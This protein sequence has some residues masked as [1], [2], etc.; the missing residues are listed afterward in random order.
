MNPRHSGTRN[1][2]S[3]ALEL[4]SQ[5][6]NQLACLIKPSGGSGRGLSYKEY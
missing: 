5:V 6:Q 4:F 3:L 1:I 2:H